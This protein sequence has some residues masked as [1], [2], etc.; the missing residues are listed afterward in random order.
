MSVR[1]RSCSIFHGKCVRVRHFG[2][3]TVFV[4]VHSCLKFH[5]GNFGRN[6]NLVLIRPCHAPN[7]KIDDILRLRIG[8]DSPDPRV[9]IFEINV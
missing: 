6:F 7:S 8:E 3:K 1:V 5:L 9:F 4:F 2:E